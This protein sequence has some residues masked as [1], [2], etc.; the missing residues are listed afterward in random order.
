MAR[1]SEGDLL[2]DGAVSEWRPAGGTYVA[3]MVTQIPMVAI[4]IFVYLGVASHGDYPTSG[5]Y[6]IIDL[7]ILIALVVA[8]GAVH[9]AVHG[10][11]MVAFG[12][13]P[14]FGILRI[15]GLVVGFYAT[16]PGHRFT[17]RQYVIVCLVPLAILAPLGVPACLLPF[18]TYL[19]VPFA[20]HLAGCVGDLSI[21]W[22]VLRGPRGVLVEDL[23][24][25]MRLWKATV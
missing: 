7:V 17:R 14:E 11:F 24:D 2:P 16:A 3:W 15:E 1:L 9:E 18:G 20:L 23:R 5:T 25:G 10:A 4:G 19:V 21:A 22:H 12:A 6:S 13:R 8:L